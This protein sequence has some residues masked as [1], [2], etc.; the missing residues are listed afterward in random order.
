LGR[1]YRGFL[2][3]LSKS[4][5]RRCSKSYSSSYEHAHLLNEAV[6]PLSISFNAK[7]PIARSPMKKYY[8]PLI[9]HINIPGSGSRILLDPRLTANDVRAEKR[10]MLSLDALTVI[11]I[12]LTGIRT[13]N[14]VHTSCVI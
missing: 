4:C 13:N 1:Y 12:D 3:N 9:F 6:P 14:S 5:L 10:K 11:I 8:H 7:T 2:L